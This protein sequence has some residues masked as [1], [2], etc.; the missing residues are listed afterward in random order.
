MPMNSKILLEVLKQEDL[1][2][3]RFP[4]RQPLI[5]ML[6][7]EV[8]KWPEIEIYAH[9]YGGTEFRLFNKSIGHI[10]SNGMLDLPFVKDVR[11]RLLDENLVQMHHINQTMNWV[12]K[13]I[14]CDD[15]LKAAK[16]LLLLSYFIKGQLYFDRFEQSSSFIHAKLLNCQFSETIFATDILGKHLP[17]RK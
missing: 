5:K 13:Q 6:I 9:I 11:K 4:E 15:D 17:Q 7:N 8:S 3:K 1:N 14:D 10:H 16:S 2:K 12:T